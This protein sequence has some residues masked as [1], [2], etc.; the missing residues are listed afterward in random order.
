MRPDRAVGEQVARRAERAQLPGPVATPLGAG[1]APVARPP[2]GRA[3]PPHEGE[4][5]LQVLGAGDV[6]AGQL[7]HAARCRATPPRARAAR[8][9]RPALVRRHRLAGH[10]AH[11]VVGVAGQVAGVVEPGSARASGA[12]ASSAE[13]TTAE[14][15]STRRQVD[16]AAVRRPV[17]LLPGRR[18]ALRPGRLVPAVAEHHAG[19]GPARPAFSTRSRQS[20]RRGGR[21]EVEPGQRQ[22]G[23]RGVH[24]G[25]DEGR[26]HQR[27]GEVDHLVGAVARAARGVPADPGDGAA[28]DQQCGRGR[29]GRGCGRA[30]RGRASWVPSGIAVSLPAGARRAAGRRARCAAGP[31]RVA[32]ARGRSRCRSAS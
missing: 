10:P 2:P 32:R 27:A 21:R 24:V 14:C 8:C 4:Q 30:R 9:D 12:A 25:V 16:H 23:G 22:P 3:P 17:E 6:R 1:L 18:P 19:R 31:A 29:V 20:A 7:V 13:D 15:T 28:A 11:D 26:G 5:G